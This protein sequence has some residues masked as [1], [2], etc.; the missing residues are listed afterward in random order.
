MIKSRKRY[1]DEEIRFVINMYPKMGSKWVADK[2]NRNYLA[3]QKLAQKLGVHPNNS[4]LYTSKEGYLVDCK[5]RN[6]R[7][8][9]HRKVMEKHL[10]RKLHSHEIVHH[11]DG[12]KKNNHYSN[13]EIMTR[14]DHMNHHREQLLEGKRRKNQ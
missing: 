11:K 5:D 1:T 8:Q 14:S 13:L 6:N 9:V 10:G 4:Y 3:I 12:N 7:V 2:L